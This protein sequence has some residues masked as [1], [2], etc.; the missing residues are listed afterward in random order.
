MATLGL[1][2]CVTIGLVGQDREASAGPPGA[3]NLTLYRA[4]RWRLL[5]PLGIACGAAMTEMRPIAD[6][7]Y[8][9]FLLLAFDQVV[10]NVAK[11]RY[12]SGA[13]I[14]VK[15]VMRAP[16]GATGRGSQHVQSLERYFTGVPGL[17]VVAVSTTPRESSRRPSATT[18]R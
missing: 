17:K 6:V 11:R 9:D 16:V 4:G 15:L 13:Q 14:R 5:R 18:T 12:L 10:N 3:S 8:G 1:K 2:T 7:Q